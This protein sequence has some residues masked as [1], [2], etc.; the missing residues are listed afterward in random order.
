[1]SHPGPGAATL[2]PK[3][4]RRRCPMARLKLDLHDIYNRGSAI[5]R[6]LERVIHEAVDKK[7]REVEIIPAGVR[8]SSRSGY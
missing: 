6:E 2:E 7:I 3:P 4:I 8:G 1:M 5:D